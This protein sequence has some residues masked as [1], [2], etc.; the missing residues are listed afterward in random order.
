MWTLAS[1]VV[2]AFIANLHSEPIPN[3]EFDRLLALAAHGNL[4]PAADLPQY[5]P[6]N[7][8]LLD[9]YLQNPGKFLA[10]FV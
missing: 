1:L 2:M 10:Y 8:T 3:S 9:K 4:T 7:R 6:Y 5:A